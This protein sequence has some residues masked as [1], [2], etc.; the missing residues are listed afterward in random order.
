MP[1]CTEVWRL[2]FDNDYLLGRGE[3]V[4]DLYTLVAP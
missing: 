4:D 2:E 1:D 3:F